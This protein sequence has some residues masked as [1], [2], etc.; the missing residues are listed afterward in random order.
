MIEIQK[1]RKLVNEVYFFLKPKMK[2]K[3]IHNIVKL[4]L[5]RVMT[6]PMCMDMKSIIG[7]ET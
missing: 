6:C 5:Y 4:K 1:R 7:Y 2:N 3:K